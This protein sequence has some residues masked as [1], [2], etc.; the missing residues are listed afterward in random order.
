[1]AELFERTIASGKKAINI[2]VLTQQMEAAKDGNNESIPE[3]NESENNQPS[4]PEI[5]PDEWE[6]SLLNTPQEQNLSE[7]QLPTISQLIQDSL[8]SSSS[9]NVIS[10]PKEKQAKKNLSIIQK[11]IHL[12]G[13]K[14][15]TW[16][17]LKQ[18]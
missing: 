1:M 2:N 6:E 5:L 10:L 17:N 13:R 8:N 12:K 15:R 3:K 18:L 16:Y 11:K 4:S 7:P 9:F 14:I